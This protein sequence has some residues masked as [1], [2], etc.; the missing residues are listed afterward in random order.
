MHHTGMQRGPAL[1]WLLQFLLGWPQMRSLLRWCTRPHPVCPPLSL[2]AVPPLPP[3]PPPPQLS[4]GQVH[5]KANYDKSYELILQPV[6]AAVLL[7]F[8]DGARTPPASFPPL[9]LAPLPEMAA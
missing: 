9:L 4:L 5:I 8:N 2:T 6:Q 1:I 7:A 3:P